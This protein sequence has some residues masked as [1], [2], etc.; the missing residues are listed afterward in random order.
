[1]VF[2]LSIGFVGCELLCERS[3]FFDCFYPTLSGP[4][5]EPPF[6]HRRS[7]LRLTNPKAVSHFESCSNVRAFVTACSY[8]VVLSKVAAQ[9]GD[10]HFEHPSL[11]LSV[12]LDCR[13]CTQCSKQRVEKGETGL[14]RLLKAC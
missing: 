10:E 5:E 13:S 7:M 3:R 8:D 12:V 2:F 9:S 14:V 1:M 4:S 6:R 11:L